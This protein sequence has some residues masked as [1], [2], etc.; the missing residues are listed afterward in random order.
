MLLWRNVH[1]RYPSGYGTLISLSSA[2]FA[3][4]H[5]AATTAAITIGNRGTML[6]I[7]GTCWY[8]VQIQMKKEFCAN[9]PQSNKRESESF[10]LVLG[11]RP[12]HA[13]LTRWL[14]DE[15]RGAILDG[16]LRPGARLPATRDLARQYGLSRGI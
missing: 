12:K 11:D 9:R 5:A 4:R 14:L 6:S 10:P 16:R 13:T 3:F 7:L 2:P 15:L 1:W 8:T